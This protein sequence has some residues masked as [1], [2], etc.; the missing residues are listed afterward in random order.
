MVPTKEGS[1]SQKLWRNSMTPPLT[2]WPPGTD[3]QNLNPSRF[4]MSWC[5]W[6]ARSR[7]T[8]TGWASPW[9]WWRF[10]QS[11]CRWA[12]RGSGRRPPGHRP[13]SGWRCRP[14]PS[15]PRST[16]RCD[17]TPAAR[18]RC[19]PVRWRRP[20]PCGTLEWRSTE[21]PMR[22]NHKRWNGEKNLPNPSQTC[23]NTLL[24]IVCIFSFYVNGVLP[25]FPL[26]KCSK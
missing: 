20:G 26:Y 2:P 17:G 16:G 7:W 21:E 18:R 1:C 19:G 12:R 8:D 24:C 4:F 13:A 3:L 22:N 11:G 15:G 23:I 6:A 10:L 25:M 14:A 5:V 9:R